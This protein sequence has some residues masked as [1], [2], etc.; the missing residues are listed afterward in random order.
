MISLVGKDF[1]LN[2]KKLVG[3]ASLVRHL[4]RSHT[5]K[6]KTGTQIQKAEHL[7]L[8]RESVVG[9]INAKLA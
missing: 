3:D 8:N 5:I 1:K 7:L 4:L 9:Q 6:D 2:D